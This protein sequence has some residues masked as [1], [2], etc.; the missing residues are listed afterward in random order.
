MEDTYVLLGN[1]PGVDAGTL[2]V[3]LDNGEHLFK[4]EKSGIGYGFTIEQMD[5]RPEWFATLKVAAMN[6]AFLKG[7]SKR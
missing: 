3:K 5:T 2:S 4:D 1:M 7:Q 6:Y